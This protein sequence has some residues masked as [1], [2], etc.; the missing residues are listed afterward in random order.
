MDQILQ[1][2][3]SH[4]LALCLCL[5]AVQIIL[6]VAAFRTKKEIL[7]IASAVTPVV[8]AVLTLHV[9]NNGQGY[10]MLETCLIFLV[11]DVIVLLITVGTR[12]GSE[13]KKKLTLFWQILWAA[14][15]LG[16]LALVFYIFTF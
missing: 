5:L 9:P 1:F 12:A 7:W 13:Q 4:Y 2:L 16:I 14:M 8:S 6:L 10:S 15:I 11:F 3:S